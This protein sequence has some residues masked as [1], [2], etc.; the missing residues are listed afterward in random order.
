MSLP[1]AIALFF[2]I[3]WVILFAVLPFGVRTQGESGSV[4]PGTPES[5]PQRFDLRRVALINTA[6]AMVVFAVVWVFVE[7]DLLSIAQ[8][9]EGTSRQPPGVGR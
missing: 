3:W 8:L 2:V 6:V 5:A 4:V 7:Y 9:A 1:L